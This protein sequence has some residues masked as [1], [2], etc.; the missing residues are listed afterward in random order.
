MATLALTLFLV[1]SVNSAL[2]LQPSFSHLGLYVK[3]LP[4]MERFY[5]HVLGF[6]V[7]DRLGREIRKWCF[8]PVLFWSII[9]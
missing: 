9:N 4:V 3:S 8:C 5:C 7:T 2:P 1:A 6:H